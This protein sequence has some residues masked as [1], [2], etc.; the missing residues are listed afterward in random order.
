MG[1]KIKI[2]KKTSSDQRSVEI[3]I[4]KN[5]KA[6]RRGIETEVVGTQ[7]EYSN[8]NTVLTTSP[9][10]QTTLFLTTYLVAGDTDVCYPSAI[11]YSQSLAHSRFLQFLLWRSLSC[12][13]FLPFELVG[14]TIRG[15]SRTKQRQPQI[16]QRKN[17]KMPTSYSL[18]QA[19]KVLAHAL[20][21]NI[22]SIRPLI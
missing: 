13:R 6:R 14:F 4:P 18:R 5:P 17:S 22:P 15:T 16:Q 20:L 2:N 11:R 19:A 3:R 7:R 10:C 1:H 9:T 21:P 12:D 8:C